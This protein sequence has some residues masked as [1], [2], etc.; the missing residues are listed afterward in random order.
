MVTRF[1]SFVILGAMRTGSNFLEASL[2]EI[3]G[4]TSYGEV[5]NPE[6]IGRKGE[7]E[8]L[9]VTLAMREANP[10]VVLRRMREATEGIPGFRFFAGHDPRAF[11]AAMNDPGCAKIILSRNPVES[12]VSLAIAG[13][14]GQWMLRNERR[15]KTARV[16]FDGRAF[17]V[18]LE[19]LRSFYADVRR[20]LRVGGQA[21]FEIDYPSLTDPAVLNGLAAWLGARG[22]IERPSGAL[23]RQN[24]G[25]LA[26]KVV[27]PDEMVAALAAVAAEGAPA[28]AA[29]GPGRGPAIATYVAA[30][31]APLLHLPIQGGPV[32]EV[33]AWLAAIDGVGPG[34][35][36]R[37]FTR[38]AL[39]A[40]RAERPGHRSF[41]VVSHPL[42]RAHRVFV[43]KIVAPD[44][45]RAIRT[46]LREL[47]R[48]DLPDGETTA[49]HS[50]GR[51]RAAFLGFLGFLAENL[52][53]RTSIRQDAAWA[54]QE[55]V[56]Q[57][58]ATFRAPDMILRAEA[59]AEGLGQLAAQVGRPAPAVPTPAAPGPFCLGDI[60]DEEIERAAR[61][62]Y[63]RD[64]EAFGYADWSPLTRP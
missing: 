23:V 31:K 35:L 32:A 28:E 43:T 19:E 4:L 8:L 63:G 24:P 50:R 17:A 18:Y 61:T 64:Y 39:R 14:T 2:N 20:R 54:P 51:H 57:G 15:R 34:T 49:D 33:E 37:D 11:E 5:F 44:G 62:A 7:T 6:F 13:Q 9:G 25:P 53:G 58:F 41:A 56:L 40:W 60:H 45:Y 26:E 3:A 55:V 29:A 59:L 48:L 22:R 16:V 42:P 12:F 36:R 27:N 46:K 30:A 21:G 1:A 47:Y 38:K 52:A 10:L